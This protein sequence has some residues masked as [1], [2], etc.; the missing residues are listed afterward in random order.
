MKKVND[1]D[2]PTPEEKQQAAELARALDSNERYG[3]VSEELLETAALLK[4]TRPSVDLDPV[5]K[6]AILEQLLE[7]D[8]QK[9][10]P[11]W[12]AAIASRWATGAALASAVAVLALVVV[13]KRSGEMLPTELPPPSH[14]LLAAQLAAVSGSASSL[15]T[16]MA[17]YR[18]EVYGALS[19]RYGAG[20]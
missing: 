11:S 6:A 13:V 12:W 15:E 18:G 10:E 19:R 1:H 14:G 17:H 7:R 9:P 3:G 5:K 8:V 4:H 16:E 2:D 20:E